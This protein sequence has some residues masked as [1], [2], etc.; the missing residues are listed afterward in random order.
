M[1]RRVREAAPDPPSDGEPQVLLWVIAVLI[2]V[3]ELTWWL[4]DRM[5]ST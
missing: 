5:Y 3:L 4:F 2:A 1:N